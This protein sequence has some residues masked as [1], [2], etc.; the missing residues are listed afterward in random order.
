MWPFHLFSKSRFNN[1]FAR[2]TFFSYCQKYSVLFPCLYD[3]KLFYCSIEETRIFM[4]NDSHKCM[5][6]EPI[7]SSSSISYGVF[8]AYFLVVWAVL[9]PQEIQHLKQPLGSLC[10]AKMSKVRG[11]EKLF[12][13][14]WIR[15]SWLIGLCCCQFSSWQRRGRHPSRLP[16]P[17]R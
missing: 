13:S 14:I 6:D 10:F 5:R 16:S 3:P 1:N 7:F 15:M 12:T 9:A 2:A 11:G 17:I 4:P 8:S